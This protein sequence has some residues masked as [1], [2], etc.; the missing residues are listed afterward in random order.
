MALSGGV[1]IISG[2]HNFLDLSKAGFLS[3][4]GQCKPFDAQADGYCRA[5]GAGLIVL[6]NLNQAIADGNQIH[7]VIPGVATNQGGLSASITVPHSVAQKKLYETVLR[8]AGLK[9]E[10]VSYVEAH[11]TGTSM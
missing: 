11:G 3:P 1:N 2:I 9:A 4:T 10:Q 8:Q 5:E 6:K 7:G